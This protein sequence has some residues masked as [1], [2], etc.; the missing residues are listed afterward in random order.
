MSTDLLK[1]L[2]TLLVVLVVV[3]FGLRLLR[4]SRQDQL[5][6][7]KPP[8]V[9]AK[10]V[11]RIT[12][13]STTDTIRL[14]KQGAGWTVNGYAAAAD[15]AGQLL[16]AVADTGAR[17]ELVAES[18]ASHERLGV[19]SAHAHT[20]VVEGGGKALLTVLIGKRGP[21]WE[22]AYLR[23]P[24]AKAVYQVRGRLI[25][26]VERRVDDWRDKLIL[27][28]EPDS[29]ET[30]EVTRGKAHYMVARS[31]KSWTVGAGP[32]DSSAA[33]NLFRQFKKLEASGFATKAQIDSANF[34]APDRLIKL[35]AKGGRPLAVLTLDSMAT[36]FW[37]KRDTSSIIFKIDGY[38][39]GQ[40]APSDSTL[41][42]K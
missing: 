7:F 16:E 20:L 39:A 23:F 8:A 12:L 37:V 34:G 11:D 14:A 5:A 35:T 29:I 10:S 31:G 26:Y 25:E 21:N 22:S 6:S 33:A 18:A 36:G 13:R 27:A 41:K 9:D 19:D 1:R 38:T 15:L 2:S 42:K 40:L 4:K 3:W 32:A 28:V 24:G 30:L 17:G